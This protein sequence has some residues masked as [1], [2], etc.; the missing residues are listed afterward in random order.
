M[1]TTRYFLCVFLFVLSGVIQLSAQ[2][3]EIHQL[4]VGSG[5]AAIILTRKSNNSINKIMIIDFG[6]AFSSD[7]VGSYLKDVLNY[8]GDIDYAIV[9][10]YDKDHYGGYANFADKYLLKYGKKIKTLII[11]GGLSSSF[12]YP[13]NGLT[14]KQD[15]WNPALPKVTNAKKLSELPTFLSNIKDTNCVSSIF[16]LSEHKK[17]DG[18]FTFDAYNNIPIEM[19]L[20]AGLQYIKGV[21]KR[22]LSKNRK[23]ND[24]CLAWV[25]HFGQFRFYTGGDLGGTDNGYVDHESPLADYFISSNRFNAKSL[26]TTNKGTLTKGHVCVAKINHHGS[27]ESS[28]A[29]FLKTTNPS[30]WIISCGIFFDHPDLSVI[31]RMQENSTPPIDEDGIRGI[32]FTAPKEVV[33]RDIAKAF[34]DKKKFFLEYGTTKINGNSAIEPLGTYTIV[35]KPT[36]LVEIGK[37]DQDSPVEEEVPITKRSVFTI[38]FLKKET[39]G[40]NYETHS[41]LFDCHTD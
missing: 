41:I 23:G 18:N 5:D 11:P 8:S 28:N 30:A 25:L 7:L 33:A 10:H 26:N 1:K 2:Q 40:D 29:K 14:P 31:K 21:T 38:E 34:S 3:L 37:M 20:V 9:S 32:F 16:Q 15:D 39:G 19:E 27:E 36:N 35:V 24:D 12:D 6:F 22:V 4:N 13:L 17:I